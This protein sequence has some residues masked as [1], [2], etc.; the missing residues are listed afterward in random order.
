MVFSIN[1]AEI[2]RNLYGEKW[3]NFDPYPKQ[4][5]NINLK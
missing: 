1:G 5:T 4:Y 2:I 3:I